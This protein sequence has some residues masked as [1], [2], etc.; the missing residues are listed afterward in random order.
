MYSNGLLEYYKK[1]Y[2]KDGFLEVSKLKIKESDTQSI[3]DTC[4]SCKSPVGVFYKKC[5]NYFSKEMADAEILLS[6]LYNRLGLTSAVYLPARE[7]KHKF[8][9]SN[10][11]NG[12]NIFQ[13]RIFN[14]FV[15]SKVGCEEELVTSFMNKQVYSSQ[16]GEQIVKYFSR[17]ALSQK[18][19]MRV[20][21]CA[22]NNPDREDC[23]YVFK[24]DD[25]NIAQDIIVFDH[26]RSGLESRRII[27][28]KGLGIP[29]TGFCNDF[30]VE[31]ASREDVLNQIKQSE[32]CN[33]LVDRHALAQQIGE[34]DVNAVALDICRTT[35]YMIEPSYTDY[36]AKSFNLTA[37]YL[38]K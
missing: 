23:N 30:G 13:A 33:K 31:N 27:L 25:D 29:T 24:V 38:D 28:E 4:V 16:E 22:A 1:A 17:R 7:G 35:G 15:S 18:I 11:V 10:S 36:I 5:R 9:L 19:K 26:E 20:L 32:L 21:D 12:K 3:F 37:N 2:F 34:V 8:L 14:G 6:Q